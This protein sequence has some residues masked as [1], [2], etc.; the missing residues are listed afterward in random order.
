[1]AETVARHVGLGRAPSGTWVVLLL[2]IAMGAVLA[3][4]SWLLLRELP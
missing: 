1:M 2:L 4:A 3:T